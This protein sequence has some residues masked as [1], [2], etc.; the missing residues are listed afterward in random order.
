MPTL[1]I[2]FTHY[3]DMAAVESNAILAVNGDG[4]TQGGREKE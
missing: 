1:G 2:G 3:S 4:Q